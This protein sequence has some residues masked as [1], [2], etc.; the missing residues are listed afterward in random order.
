MAQRV[1]AFIMVAVLLSAGLFAADAAFTEAGEDKSNINE[2]FQNPTAGDV[3]QL[4]DSEV[5]GAFYDNE[6]IVYNDSTVE[7]SAGTDYE[8]I[9]DNGT[10]RPLA[11]GEL[12][13]DTNGTISYSYD[14]TTAE[15]RGLADGMQLIFDA[16]PG[17]FIVG[18]LVFFLLI[19]RGGI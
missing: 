9:Q 19:I 13:G 3:L 4:D 12:A 1:L 14:E 15:Q 18:A 7:M 5:T 2:T 6:T 10:L 11:G 16:L 17:I 8:W